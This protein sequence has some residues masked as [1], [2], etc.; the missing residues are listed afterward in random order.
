MLMLV[1]T[2]KRTAKEKLKNEE[3]EEAEVLNK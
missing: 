1:W 2:E 3:E